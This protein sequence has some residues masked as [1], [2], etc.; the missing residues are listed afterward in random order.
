LRILGIDCGSRLT[1]YGVI[2]SDGSR[3]SLVEAG[4]IRTRASDPFAE[5]LKLIG[6]RLREIVSLHAPGEAAVEETFQARNAQS[7]LKLTQV[8]GVALFVL[9]EAGVPVG[10]Y[11][12]AEVKTSVTGSG[13]AE[14][15]EVRWML[16]SLLRLDHEIASL[17]ASDA[18]AVALCHAVHRSV[19][20]P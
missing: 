11:S 14:K 16:R 3:H 7:A 5:R 1:G 10:E 8:R 2:D 17:D 19:E 12:P 15:E 20:A 18:V 6:G 13:R 4:V 9:A